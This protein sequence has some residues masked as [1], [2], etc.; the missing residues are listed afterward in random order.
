MS[1][2][3]NWLRD[4]FANYSG[5]LNGTTG[6][7]VVKRYGYVNKLLQDTVKT[8][9][10][11]KL[12]AERV[13]ELDLPARA[14]SISTTKTAETALKA[15]QDIVPGTLD[16]SSYKILSTA[17]ERSRMS[18]SDKAAVRAVLKGKISESRVALNSDGT[19]TSETGETPS[20]V[21]EN[22]LPESIEYV[23]RTKISK[24]NLESSR[25]PDLKHISEY[26]AGLREFDDVVKDYAK[27]YAEKVKS[28]RKWQWDEDIF[29]GES[30]TITQKSM[31]KAVA[32]NNADIPNVQIVKF[33]GKTYADFENAGVVTEIFVLPKSMWNLSD[34]AQFKWLDEQIGGHKVGYTWHHSEIPGIMELVPFGIHNITYHNGG[35]TRGM[36]A[37]AQR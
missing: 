21:K 4:Q 9:P 13:S 17:L 6:E 10:P 1:D 22:S 32:V 27:L 7:D 8:A 20:L 19:A 16:Q 11:L 36:W 3:V 35:R 2:Y 25:K 37:D 31:I 29:G 30:L 23:N 15:L 24:V 26:V 18:V 33:D 12:T 34:A 5:A 28:N 14:A